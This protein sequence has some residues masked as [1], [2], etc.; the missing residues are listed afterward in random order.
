MWK[1]TIVIDLDD[2]IINTGETVINLYNKK[3]PKEKLIYIEN[4]KWGFA[5]I[6]KTEE[7]FNKIMNLFEEEDFYE[8]III[9]DNSVQIINKLSKIFN[10]IICSK[11]SEKRRGI[12]L[13]WIRQVMPKVKVSF[14]D[15]FEEK[16]KIANKADIIIDDKPESFFKLSK[17]VIPILFGNYEWNKGN[18]YLRANNWNE[19]EFLI[20]TIIEAKKNNSKTNSYYVNKK[21]KD[22]LEEAFYQK[23]IN[24]SIQKKQNE[25]GINY[26]IEKQLYPLRKRYYKKVKEKRIRKNN[27]FKLTGCSYK[28]VFDYQ[29]EVW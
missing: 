24:C 19:L 26:Y 9:R 12:T 20:L 17:K 18:D 10:I 23:N 15:E 3:Y 14:V 7:Q 2:T 8:N 6:I 25:K 27:T 22:K 5:P 29:W 1:P 16:Y 28:K 21:H 4:H 11:H 13:K